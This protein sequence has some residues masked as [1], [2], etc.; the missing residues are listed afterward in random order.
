MSITHAD[1]DRIA[2]LAGLT[3][4]PEEKDRLIADL[5]PL[6][7]GIAA[8]DAID[9]T[10]VAPM[11]ALPV[12]AAPRPDEERPSAPRDEMLRAAPDTQDGMFRVP[13]V[14]GGRP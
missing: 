7:D 14:M 2:A 13:G 11:D 6:L 1:I 3:F 5:T 9:T 12:D 10:G 8:L 4:S